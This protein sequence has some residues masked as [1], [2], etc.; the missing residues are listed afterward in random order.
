MRELLLEVVASELGHVNR[1]AGVVAAFHA[2][3][4]QRDLGHRGDV[5][6]QAARIEWSLSLNASSSVF[7]I[8]CS[9]GCIHNLPADCGVQVQDP[10]F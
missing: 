5:A 9:P 1:H 8:D 3:L 2:R 4:S 7:F 6:A 10:L